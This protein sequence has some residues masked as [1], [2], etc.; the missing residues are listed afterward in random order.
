MRL[1]TILC[2]VLVTIFVGLALLHVFWALGGQTGQP[3]AV[4]TAGGRPLFRPSP[5]G[6]GAVAAALGVAAF[7]VAWN[8]GWIRQV[9][10]SSVS[11]LLTL[12]IAVVFLLR[13]V[14]EF[15]YVGFFKQ[16]SQS[17]F[18]YWDTRLY[19]PLCLFVAVVA[20]TLWWSP[21]RRSQR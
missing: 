9:A 11:R 12:G 15:R 7:I 18:A 14:G 1:R 2:A 4:P 19:S 20:F 10:P 8:S 5:L 16:P 3:A 21:S 13:A 6:T 17:A